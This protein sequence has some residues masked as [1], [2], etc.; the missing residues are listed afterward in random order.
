MSAM[1]D[2]T[3]EKYVTQFS[4]ETVNNA[5]VNGAAV[6]IVEA[7]RFVFHIQLHSLA[8]ST[9]LTFTVQEATASGGYS[10]VTGRTAT[11]GASDDDNFIVIDV[12]RAD[13]AVE[14]AT[15][16]RLSVQN[17]AASAAS[18]SAHCVLKGMDMPPAQGSD[19]TIV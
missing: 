6:D 11:A 8:A 4:D 17:A 15:R 2:A 16:I 12:A 1:H 14:D 5:T 9:N 19:V 7:E 18:F 10:P 13:L 3:L